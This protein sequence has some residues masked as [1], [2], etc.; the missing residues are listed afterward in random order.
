LPQLRLLAVAAVVVTLVPFMAV[1]SVARAVVVHT[2]FNKAVAL[3]L[4]IKVLRVV[5]GRTLAMSLVVAVVEH[6]KL[7]VMALAA[8]AARVE[9]A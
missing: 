2:Q 4:P 5:M 7:V 9:M 8:L 1:K 3:E 6:H